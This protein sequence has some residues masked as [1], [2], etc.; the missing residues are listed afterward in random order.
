LGIVFLLSAILLLV[1]P[2]AALIT[3]VRLGGWILI[4]FGIVMLV[5]GL[6]GMR[7]LNK[8]DSLAS[9]ARTSGPQ[10]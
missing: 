10:E 3:F 1:F 7:A 8:V 9:S 4:I 6:L 5:A 2:A